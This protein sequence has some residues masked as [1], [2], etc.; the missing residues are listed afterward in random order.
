MKIS[1]TSKIFTYTILMIGS[2]FIGIPFYLTIVSTFK[3]PAQ[4]SRNFFAPPSGLYLENIQIILSKPDYFLALKNTVVIT[5]FS[6][7]LMALFLPMAA[8]PISRRMGTSK[9]YKFMYYFMVAGIFIP[10][11][12]K[13]MPLVKVMNEVGLLNRTGIIILYLAG[14]TCEGIFLYVG[15]LASIPNDLEEAAYIDGAGTAGTFFKIITPLIKPMTATVLIKNG[16]WVWNDF[17]MP[18]LVLNRSAAY[19]TLPLFQYT[20]KTEY[21]VDYTLAFTAFLFSMLP[22]MLL[23]F[24]LQKHIIG[25]IV[26]G[27]V[28]G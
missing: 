18:S 4:M 19:K 14:S 11:Q 28:K 27:A 3:S 1:R 16:L 12:V 15:Y 7:A 6:L 20:F 25:G 5:V 17:F 26:S 21:A 10:F 8:Y 22:V 13:M 2:V 23:Y 9:G 24:F